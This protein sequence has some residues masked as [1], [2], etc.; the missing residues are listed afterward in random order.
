M[1]QLLVPKS[2]P[3][4]KTLGGWD[5]GSEQAPWIPYIILVDIQ[6]IPHQ[7]LRL[8]L[9]AAWYWSYRLYQ[10]GLCLASATNLQVEK[11]PFPLKNCLPPPFS[12]K[13]CG[14]VR[15]LAIAYSLKLGK[16]LEYKFV[17]EMEGSVTSPFT[18]EECFH[19]VM[20][21]KDIKTT[22]IH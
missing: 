4:W 21:Q 20:H 18:G 13:W 22:V 3:V 10:A 7:E 14:Y 12:W 6:R 15:A 2:P 8:Q 19:R 17:N 9:C 11:D 16:F 1:T 5:C